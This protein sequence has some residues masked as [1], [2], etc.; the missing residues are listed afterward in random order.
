MRTVA[1]VACLTA[2][3]VGCEEDGG[4][5]PP[6]PVGDAG[7]E[8]AVEETLCPDAE[9]AAVHFVSDN[10]NECSAI[11]LVCAEGQHGFNNSCGCGCIDEGGTGCPTPGDPAITWI[12]QDPAECDAVPP[13][14][15]LDD[16]GF[17]NSCGCGCIAHR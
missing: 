14:C 10:P 16:V 9:N 3:S 7:A 4:T 2:L 6:E 11:D 8:G 15:P 17:S 13:E 1:V 5:A 12:S